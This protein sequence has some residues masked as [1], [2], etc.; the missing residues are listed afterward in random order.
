[1]KKIPWIDAYKG[2]LILLVVAG[3]AIGSAIHLLPLESVSRTF[4]EGAFKFIYLFHMPAFFFIAGVTFGK[5]SQNT[6]KQFMVRKIQR[7][8]VPYFVFGV[9]SAVVYLVLSG[10]FHGAVSVHSTD[11]Y[12]GNKAGVAW[13]VP[14][15]GLL[16]GGGMPGGMGFVANLVLWFLPCLFMVEV[17]YFLLDRFVKTRGWQLALAVLLFLSAY[18]WKNVLSQPLPWGLYQ[19]PYYLPFLILG[20]WL[21]HN[22]SETVGGRLSLSGI[23]IGAVLLTILVCGTVFTPNA[24]VVTVNYGWCLLFTGLAIVGIGSLFAII[25][26]LDW[27]WIRV[28]GRAS[29]SIM[30]LHKFPVIALQMKVSLF[31]SMTSSGGLSMIGITLVIMVLSVIAC[32]VADRLIVRYA[33]WMLGVFPKKCG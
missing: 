1:M 33:P 23:C 10:A 14:F 5:G 29:L 12:Y 21:P 26:L 8:I 13:W 27:H 28:C 31:R 20:R 17:A 30:L 22:W 6:M 4:A 32:L 24:N 25:H 18:P 19:L 9:I 11:S 15:V 7:L 3:H 2:V 16:H